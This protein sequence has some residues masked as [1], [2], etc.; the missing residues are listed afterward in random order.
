MRDVGGGGV[1]MYGILFGEEGGSTVWLGRGREGG[2]Q[3]K[4]D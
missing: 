1:K 3:G 2:E 4:M